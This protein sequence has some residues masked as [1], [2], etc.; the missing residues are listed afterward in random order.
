M[1]L[2]GLTRVLISVCVVA[3]PSSPVAAQKINAPDV[4]DTE[5]NVG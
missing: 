1:E 3:V 2:T 4:T 5:I